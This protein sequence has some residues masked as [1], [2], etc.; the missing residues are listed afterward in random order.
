V[1]EDGN[2]RDSRL[3]KRVAQD[4][5]LNEAALAAARKARFKPATR[6]GV[7]VRMWYTLTFP[8]Q[9]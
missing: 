3:V 9:L 2:V 7:R 1:V 6:E 4:V 8:F 5:G